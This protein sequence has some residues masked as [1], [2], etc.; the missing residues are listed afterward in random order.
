[1]EAAGQW[2]PPPPC[3]RATPGWERCPDASESRGGGVPRASAVI[4]INVRVA[5]IQSAGAGLPR[6]FR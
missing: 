6:A 1:M 4:E 2:P 3:G 5:R